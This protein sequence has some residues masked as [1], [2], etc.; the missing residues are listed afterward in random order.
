MWQV[1]WTVFLENPLI[2]AGTG[3]FPSVTPELVLAGKAPGITAWYDHPHNDYLTALSDRG[4]AGLAALLLLYGAPF[5]LFVQALRQTANRAEP[6]AGLLLVGGFMLS[7]LTETLFNHSLVITYY[8]VFI[9]LLA[10]LSRQ[11]PP[12]E[13]S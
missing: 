5:W 7:G 8:A 13:S 1:A 3:S 12:E 10:V 11:P 4:L 2:G 9:S 6:V